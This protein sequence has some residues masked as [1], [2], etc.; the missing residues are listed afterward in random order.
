MR[1]TQITQEQTSRMLTAIGAASVDELF[2][3]IS[4]EHRARGAIKLPGGL[5]E[6]ELMAELESLSGR[7]KA[8]SDDEMVCFLGGGVYDHFSPT[9]VNDLAMQSAFLTAYT[10]YQAEASQGLL[11]LFYEFQTLVC[12]LTGMDVANASLYEHASAVAEAVQIACA[13]TK[14]RR[15]LMSRAIHPDAYRVAQ[16]QTYEQDLELVP[17]PIDGGVTD[18]GAL[19]AALNEETAAVVVQSPNFFGQIESV[20]ELADLAHGAGALLIQSADPISC[21][22]LK[23]P[24]TLGADIAAGEAQ[25]LGIPMAYGG[26]LCGFLACREAHLRRMPGRIVGMTR[27]ADGKRA[28]CLTL[29]TREQHIRRERATSNICTN[30]GLLAT[31]VTIHTA[32]MGRSGLRQVA[33]LCVNKSRY[34]AAR[35]AELDGYR[36]KFAGPFFREFVVQSDRPVRNVLDHCQGR[37]IAAGV[38]LGGWFPELKDCFL[39]AVTEKRSRLQIDALADALKSV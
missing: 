15:V 18:A 31:R 17:L 27:D 9:V 3:G 20:A 37:G 6:P 34:A 30:Q 32:A 14:R 39:I 11:Q 22:I 35:I 28:F 26:P 8:C 12:Q 33:Q 4:H 24:A 25:P 23:R 2:K 29:Q 7:N 5:S 38:P 16:T 36:L 1:Y 10:P 21:A 19:G 13:A